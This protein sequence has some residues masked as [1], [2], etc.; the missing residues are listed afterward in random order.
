MHMTYT[1]FVARP[2]WRWVSWV[3]LLLICAAFAPFLIG[4]VGN[5]SQ[6]NW[7]FMGALHQYHHT[8]AYLTRAQQGYTGDWLVHLRYTPDAHPSALIQPLYPVLGHLARLSTIS[9]TAIFHATRLFAA[10]WMY[11]ALYQLGA[12][13]WTKI[14]TRRIFFLIVALGSGWGWISAVIT[15]GVQSPDLIYA[16]PYPFFST[17]V[18]VHEP[19]A[20]G[21]LAILASILIS[22]LRPGHQESPGMRNGGLVVILMGVAVIFLVPQSLAILLAALLLSVI[23]VCWQQRRY[24]VDAVRWFTWLLIPVLPVAAYYWVI[25]RNN[26][27]VMDWVQQSSQPVPDP[28]ALVIGLGLPLLIALPGFF[29]A[30][31]RFERD[32][33]QFML[34]WFVL[35][36]VALYL[37]LSLGPSAITGLMIPV[38]YFATRAAEDTWLPL[39]PRRRRLWGYG[40]VLALMSLSHVVVLLGP[41][42]PIFGEQ[43]DPEGMLLEPGYVEAFR[44]LRLTV[45]PDDVILAAPDDVSAWI[46][47]WTGGRTVYGHEDE[48]YHASERYALARAWYGAVDPSDPVCDKML[49]NPDFFVYFVLDGP[50]ERAYGPGACMDD[51]RFA[52]SFG[53][54]TIYANPVAFRFVP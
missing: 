7:R 35:M 54:V 43:T 45:H 33:D 15:G 23:A 37:P 49:N 14:R 29:R 36:L 22:A 41:I 5:Q 28:I 44:W 10:F 51:L 1:G 4:A 17:L 13:I 31:R 53:S 52:A 30:L 11:A 19:L 2:E 21:A 18:S 40:I 24:D 8:A 25:L 48:T 32:G 9:V 39:L 47:F 46:P 12:S 16:S 50:R 27:V 6:D 26:P 20:I 38:A 34:L 42:A 3:S